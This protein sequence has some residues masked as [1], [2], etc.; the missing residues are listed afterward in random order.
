MLGYMTR[1]QAYQNDFTHHG[2]YYGI[3]VWITNEEFPRVAAKWLPMELLV[4]VFHWIEGV[5]HSLFFPHVEP[6]FK[7]TITEPISPFGEILNPGWI[8]GPIMKLYFIIT[9]NHGFTT[10]WGIYY[11]T[12]TPTFWLRAHE[13]S[14]MIDLAREGWLKYSFH[15]LRHAD[16]EHDDRPAEKSADDFADYWEQQFYQKYRP[17]GVNPKSLFRLQ[18]E[19]LNQVWNGEMLRL[20]QEHGE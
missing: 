18:T 1:H 3:P 19:F 14:H 6:G 13:M 8:I 2:R 16:D 12:A 11:Q 9:G 4:T 5:L 10:Y 20:K 7:F 17:A 15:I